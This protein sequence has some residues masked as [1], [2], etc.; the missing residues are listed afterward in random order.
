MAAQVVE[1]KPRAEYTTLRLLGIS[2]SARRGSFNTAL[3]KAAAELVP[4]GVVLEV[5]DISVLP[6]FNQDLEA[7]LPE[8]V[9]R[10]KEAVRGA[11]GILFATPEHNYS[12]TALLKNAIEWGS[13]PEIDNSW[14]GK[15]AAIMSASTSLRG[16]A[17]S[18][19]A[20]RQIL[21]DVNVYA[22]NQ[23]QLMVAKA[24]EKFDDN[25]RLTD[26]KLRGRLRD[27]VL[28]LVEWTGKMQ[29]EEYGT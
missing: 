13:R 21:V 9:V 17:R 20:L 23:P 3:L 26:E 29:P 4:S 2:G 18:Q 12:V 25:S 28:A 10:F 6:L 16:G 1:R 11:D 5:F 14:D 8:P 15:P 7:I 22:M 27:L 24:E 19:M